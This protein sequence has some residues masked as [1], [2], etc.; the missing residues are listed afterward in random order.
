MSTPPRVGFDLDL[1]LL[2]LRAATELALRVTNT[3]LGLAIDVDAVLADLGVPFREQLATWVDS[4]RMDVAMRVFHREFMGAG[5]ARINA[6]PGAEDVLGAIRAGGGFSVVI[7]GRRKSV[8]LACLRRCGLSVPVV[9]GSV[10]GEEKSDAMRQHR[11]AAYVGDH[12]LDMRAATLAGVVG[13]GVG[14]GSYGER[15]LTDA[16]ATA[17]TP[18]LKELTA[19]LTPG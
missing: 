17:F 18:T 11:I 3:R 12:L 10:V 8:A 9:V 14:T 13:I 5:L 7:T 6:L 2:D 16:G 1:T 19:W 4:A 15:E